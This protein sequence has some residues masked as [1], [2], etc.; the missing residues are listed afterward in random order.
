MKTQIKN[1][2]RLIIVVLLALSIS[3]CQRNNT[4]DITLSSLEETCNTS[5]FQGARPNIS[6]KAL[7]ANCGEPNDFLDLGETGGTYSPTYYKSKGKIICHYSKEDKKYGIGMV[8]YVPYQNVTMHINDFLYGATTYYGVTNETEKVRIYR[9]DTLYYRI[10]VNNS[11]VE[12]IEYWLA[13]K[14]FMN[15]AS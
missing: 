2:K 1:N 9:N 11:I 12:S 5:I 8:E 14:R 6:L 7:L 13:K 4:V 3:S 10:I 15:V